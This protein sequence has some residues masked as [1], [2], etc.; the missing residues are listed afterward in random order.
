MSEAE[1]TSR[2]RSTAKSAEGAET[3]TYEQ[4][5]EQGYVGTAIDDADYTVGAET[6]DITEVSVTHH[7]APQRAAELQEKIQAARE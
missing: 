6:P 2:K 5:L 3:Q 4:A 7:L 1:A